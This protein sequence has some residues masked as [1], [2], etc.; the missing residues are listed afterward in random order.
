MSYHPPRP[1]TL[2]D[3]VSFSS[4]AQAASRALVCC[5]DGPA[6][7]R[8]ALATAVAEAAA[9]LRALGVSP[10][11]VVTIVDVNTVSGFDWREEQRQREV[12]SPLGDVMKEEKGKKGGDR[13]IFSTSTSNKTLR[14]TSS[15]PSSL[16]P[17]PAPSPPP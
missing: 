8:A 14:S 13:S 1:R 12:L 11:D 9:S 16:S 4:A 2:A 3:V 10:G 6:L 7:S 5:S 15:S 17:A